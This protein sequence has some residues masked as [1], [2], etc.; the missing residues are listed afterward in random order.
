MTELKDIISITGKP[1]LYQVIAR[2]GK[3]VIVE[4]LDDKRTRMPVQNNYQV[5]LLEEITIFTE[6][7]EELTLKTVFNNIEKKDGKTLSVSFNDEP[8]KIKEY[9]SEI[10]PGFDQ[11]RVYISDMKKVLKWYELLASF[12]KIEAA[13]EATEP[14]G[15]TETKES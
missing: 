8:V 10:A 14:E 3:G 9:F 1:G 13:P 4:S 2:T 12:G 11:N 6:N 5:A 7:E 15:E